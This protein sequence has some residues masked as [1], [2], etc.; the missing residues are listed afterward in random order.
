MS[1]PSLPGER[2]SSIQTSTAFFPRRYASIG[3]LSSIGPNRPPLLLSR[4]QHCRSRAQTRRGDG[5]SYPFSSRWRRGPDWS[6]RQASADGVQGPGELDFY[7]SYPASGRKRTEEG[8]GEGG[9]EGPGEGA[10]VPDES[11]RARQRSDSNVVHRQNEAEEEDL[12]ERVGKAGESVRE[13]ARRPG[14]SPRAGGKE[15]RKA[16]REGGPQGGLGEIEESKVSA[17]RIVGGRWAFFRSMTRDLRLLSPCRSFCPLAAPAEPS[18]GGS[19][20]PRWRP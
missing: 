4:S 1:L 7:F 14:S 11:A 5:S 16:A 20:R 9:R 10:M 2:F 12:A 19:S 13:E 6:V 15:G 17:W 3:F 18:G 8:G